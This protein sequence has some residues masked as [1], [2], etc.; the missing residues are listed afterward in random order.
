MKPLATTPRWIALLLALLVWLGGCATLPYEGAPRVLY[1]YDAFYD[2]EDPF[3]LDALFESGYLVNFTQDVGDLE[4]SM[5]RRRF[6]LVIVLIQ[7]TGPAGLVLDEERLASYMN[8]GGRVIL[9]DWRRNDSLAAMFDASYTNDTNQ[10]IVNLDAALARDVGTRFVL[11]DPGWNTYSMGLAPRADAV[12]LCE[13]DDG[14]SCLIVGNG[15]RSVL[16]GMVGDAMP[17]DRGA[18]FWRNLTAFVLGRDP[19]LP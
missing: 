16:M 14:T 12:S 5:V 7:E 10:R 6:D 17:S 4:A 15:G 11:A 3:I 9:V 19:A 8:A 18:A 1:F 2:F 13:F